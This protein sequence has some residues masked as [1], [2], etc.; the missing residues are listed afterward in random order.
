MNVIK[1]DGKVEAFDFN[2]PFNALEKVYK[3]GLKIEVSTELS[4]KFDLKLSEFVDSNK[5]N[6]PINIE[7]IQDFIRDFLMDNDERE[8]AEQFIIYRDERSNYREAN[9]KLQKNIGTK[10]YAKN[11]ANQ[12]AN[13][14]EESFGGRIGEAASEVCK[15]YALKHSMSKKSKRN[16][17][18]NMIY[19]HD[20]NS[21]AVGMHNC[22][23]HTTD[24]ILEHGF[25][26]KQCDVR[27]ASSLNTA[28]Q[29]LAVNFQI[30]SLQQ[31]GGVSAGH[32]DW[33]MVPYFRKSFYKHYIDGLKY[34]EGW[35]DRKI[36]KFNKSL[37][38]S[39][40]DDIEDENVFQKFI[41]KV[42]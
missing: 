34:A 25:Q 5:N 27:P 32:L 26:V 21:F 19:Q 9:T 7:L 8:A 20:L 29:L 33:T 1:R 24:P 38:I 11:V 16:H 42:F 31:F 17:E 15:D 14:D 35:S 41:N 18:Q 37:G 39:T 3:N 22:L 2:K 4:K 13:L 12:N 40:D 36:A 10:L 30:Q 6:E 28:F 23:T